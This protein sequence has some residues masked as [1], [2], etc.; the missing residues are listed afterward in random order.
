VYYNGS[1][2][3]IG[4][5]FILTPSS[6]EIIATGE[7]VQVGGSYCPQIVQGLVGT[8]GNSSNPSYNQNTVIEFQEAQGGGWTNWNASTSAHTTNYTG[9]DFSYSVNDS[10]PHFYQFEAWNAY[11]GG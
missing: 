10:A 8:D 9:N 7:G 5:S 2:N 3:P 6:T 1:V 11:G 4:T